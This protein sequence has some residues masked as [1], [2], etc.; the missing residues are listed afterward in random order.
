MPEDDDDDVDPV[1]T[2]VAEGIVLQ[3][4]TFDRWK[5]GVRGTL[6][7][8]V[9]AVNAFKREMGG[10]KPLHQKE[11]VAYY[12]CGCRSVSRQRSTALSKKRA[13]R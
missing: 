7:S 4:A 6:K 9:E 12:E 11:H 1:V 2:A 3:R 8:C 5:A 13:R 10:V